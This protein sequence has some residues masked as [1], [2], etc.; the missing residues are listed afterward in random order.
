MLAR[1]GSGSHVT[2]LSHA[3]STPLQPVD[4]YQPEWLSASS[5]PAETAA[6]AGGNPNA[7]ARGDASSA[8][9]SLHALYVDVNR[10]NAEDMFARLCPDPDPARDLFI[11]HDP[12]PAGAFGVDS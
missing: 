8:L 9:E 7:S 11:V 10:R 3:H 4:R 5:D 12:Q 1:W 2:A 6:G